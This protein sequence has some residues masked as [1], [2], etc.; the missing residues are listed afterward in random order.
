MAKVLYKTDFH[1]TNLSKELV[2]VF[3]NESELQKILKAIITDEVR[4]NHDDKKFNIKGLVAF[5]LDFLNSKNQT[6]GLA[7][8]ELVIEQ[9]ELNTATW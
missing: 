4:E 5:H 3:T 1:H 8:F 9:I 6:Q 2:G 7:N